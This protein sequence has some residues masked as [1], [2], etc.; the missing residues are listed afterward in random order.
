MSLECPWG[1]LGQG[2][3]GGMAAR[4]LYL[5]GGVY[6]VTSTLLYEKYARAMVRYIIYEKSIALC[7][8]MREGGEKHIEP[9]S[10]KVDEGDKKNII[11]ATNFWKNND[12]DE[13]KKWLI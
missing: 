1:Y 10:G 13:I 11:G 4:A 2:G 12:G 5:W 8:L 6:S 9:I 7:H 3:L